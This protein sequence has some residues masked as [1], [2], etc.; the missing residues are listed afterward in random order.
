MHGQTHPL[1]APPKTLWNVR[2][3]PNDPYAGKN[4]WDDEFDDSW[5]QFTSARWNAVKDRSTCSAGHDGGCSRV[6]IE[7]MG[8]R[9][10]GS[11]HLGVL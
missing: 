4:V 6:A 5:A 7:S 9:L 8:S 3:R 1:A 11:V 2:E 10:F